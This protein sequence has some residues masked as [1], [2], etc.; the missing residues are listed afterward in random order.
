MFCPSES[1]CKLSTVTRPSDHRH[2]TP[3]ALGRVADLFCATPVAG[4]LMLDLKLPTTQMGLSAH[5]C[6]AV[7]WPWHSAA[8]G[9]TPRRSAG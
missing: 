7:P 1:A 2:G 9:R 8:V 4:P 5:T 6:A 3:F